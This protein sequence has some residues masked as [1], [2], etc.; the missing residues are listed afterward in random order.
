MY[1]AYFGAF[2]EQVVTRWAVRIELVA[3]ENAAGQ[4]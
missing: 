2:D 1:Y 3:R 4:E